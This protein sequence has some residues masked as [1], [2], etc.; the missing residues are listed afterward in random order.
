MLSTYIDNEKE[1]GDEEGEHVADAADGVNHVARAAA[2]AEE[3]QDDEGPQEQL[4]LEPPA[5]EREASVLFRPDY[6]LL[7]D[8]LVRG[9]VRHVL[10]D[11][12]FDHHRVRRE[13]PEDEGGQQRP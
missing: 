9:R 1:D 11:F 4:Q 3:P 8:G 12:G 6:V 5:R 10:V 2:D 7:H 13:R